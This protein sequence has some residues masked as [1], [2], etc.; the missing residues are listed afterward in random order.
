MVFHFTLPDVNIATERR[1]EPPPPM[2]K[3]P[4]PPPRSPS[5]PPRF[6]DRYEFDRV[7]QWERFGRRSPPPPFPF[8]DPYRD[9]DPYYDR[10]GPPMRGPGYGRPRD[11]PYDRYRDRYPPPRDF[12]PYPPSRERDFYR[13]PL[14]RHPLDYPPPRDERDRDHYD[15]PRG[16]GRGP[17]ERRDGEKVTDME[18]V[19]VNRQQK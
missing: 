19:V 16:P 13:D 8:R 15:Y 11:D 9:R 14:D 5:P 3:R 12:P 2:R 4:P 17:I 10:F 7:R 18:I 1:K 6:R